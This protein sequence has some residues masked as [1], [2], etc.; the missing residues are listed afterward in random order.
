MYHYGTDRCHLFMCV[1]EL[2]MVHKSLNRSSPKK[3]T[4]TLRTVKCQV[5]N[6]APNAG[7]RVDSNSDLVHALVSTKLHS[8]V[9]SYKAVNYTADNTYTHYESTKM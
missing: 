5:R 3:G 1:C 4:F 8:K 2:I 6:K 9:F 7:P